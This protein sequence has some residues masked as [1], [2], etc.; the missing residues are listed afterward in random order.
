MKDLNPDAGVAANEKLPVHSDM[1]E[2]SKDLKA[3]ISL[4]EQIR[5]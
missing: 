2:Q 5:P 4:Q 3:F 1:G